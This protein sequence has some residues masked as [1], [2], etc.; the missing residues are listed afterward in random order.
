MGQDGKRRQR[1]K[2]IGEDGKIVLRFI[3]CVLLYPMPEGK[4]R[5]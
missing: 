3:K 5:R 2:D 4:I 1:W